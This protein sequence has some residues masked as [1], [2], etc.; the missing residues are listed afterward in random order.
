MTDKIEKHREILARRAR[1][2]RVM[3]PLAML[4][5]IEVISDLQSKWSEVINGD[6]RDNRVTLN[7][8]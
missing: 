8:R 3:C 7:W 6:K 5:G 2:E 1:G 4:E